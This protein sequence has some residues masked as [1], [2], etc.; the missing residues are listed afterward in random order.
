MNSAGPVIS[1]VG[2]GCQLA[3]SRLGNG[4]LCSVSHEGGGVSQGLRG[5]TPPLPILKYGLKHP[6]QIIP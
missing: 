1:R 5:V 4:S 6:L 2:V 3:F